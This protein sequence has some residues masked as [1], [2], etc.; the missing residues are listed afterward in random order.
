MIGTKRVKSATLSVL[1]AFTSTGVLAAVPHG[2][3]RTSPD[4][5]SMI[6]HQSPGPR[7]AGALPNKVRPK[8]VAVRRAAPAHVVHRQVKP[9]KVATRRPKPVSAV[10]P[11]AVEA[12]TPIASV[13]AEA[14][15]VPATAL[16]PALVTSGEAI[17]GGGAVIGGG[18]LP[19]LAVI[20]AALAI[21][22][23]GGGGGSGSTS[24]APAA[25]EPGTWLMMILGFGFLGTTMRKRRRA[26]R[27]SDPAL[28]VSRLTAPSIA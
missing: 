10:L 6:R 9:T 3:T 15:P 5:L 18:A 23:G 28:R 19:F 25:P 27:D 20:P 1:V 2:A 13:L 8:R 7:S 21:G 22:G 26:L 14:T 16:A 12:P 4:P 24:F 17:A 11:T